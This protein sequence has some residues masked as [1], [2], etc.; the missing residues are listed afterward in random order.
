MVFIFDLKIQMAD[1]V[2]SFQARMQAKKY[3]KYWESEKD[4]KGMNIS[5]QNEWEGG[6]GIVL[7]FPLCFYS[8]NK[9]H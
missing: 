7:I 3:Y 2:P 4:A 1:A 8:L 5:E 9:I 6:K